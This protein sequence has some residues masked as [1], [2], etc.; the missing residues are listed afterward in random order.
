[1]VQVI[2]REAERS[3][4]GDVFAA[5]GPQIEK[6]AA[7]LPQLKAEQLKIAR[8]AKLTEEEREFKREESGLTRQVTI[9][10]ALTDEIIE[11]QKLMSDPTTMSL[12]AQQGLL[13]PTMK[14]LKA[15]VTQR[16]KL[17]K[18]I[19]V[20]ALQEPTAVEDITDTKDITDIT[21]ITKKPVPS[22]GLADYIEAGGNTTYPLQKLGIGALGTAGLARGGAGLSGASV[23]PLSTILGA[24]MEFIPRETG[25]DPVTGMPITQRPVARYGPKMAGR[26]GGR[27]PLREAAGQTL[28]ELPGFVGSAGRRLGGDL[29][30]I[31]Q[32]M[33]TPPPQLEMPR[34]YN[35]LEKFAYL[36]EILK[37]GG[38]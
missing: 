27:S 20:G 12:M 35:P 24:A 37:H 4:L 38:R 30:T 22:A 33:Q 7:F 1:M 13:E 15:M 9:W 3:D 14:R 8:E 34:D 2:Q 23:D 5:V 18:N 36:S 26:T 16:D 10:K 25:V 32:L 6:F 21:D 29:G 28:S 11:T 31:F 19:G 17:G